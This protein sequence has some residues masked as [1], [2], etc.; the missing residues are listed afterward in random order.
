MPV[1][2]QVMHRILNIISVLPMS[3][4][5]KHFLLSWKQKKYKSSF[6]KAFLETFFVKIIEVTG[7]R[8]EDIAHW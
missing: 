8:A 7:S 6:L 3:E 4:M 5:L 1:M 2:S